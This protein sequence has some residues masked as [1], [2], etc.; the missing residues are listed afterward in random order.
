MYIC[1]SQSVERVISG[2]NSE[3]DSVTYTQIRNLTF[4]EVKSAPLKKTDRLT[5][6]NPIL[7]V[8]TQ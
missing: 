3:D 5:V 4:N 6:I 8:S 2:L 1:S 7:I